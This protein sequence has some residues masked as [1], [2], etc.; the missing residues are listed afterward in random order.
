MLTRHN[1]L[2]SGACNSGKSSLVNAILRRDSALVSDIPGTTADP[3]RFLIEIPGAGACRIID[4]PG[5]DDADAGLGAARS[6]LAFR[7][8]EQADI[9]ILTVG[10][11]PAAEEEFSG[12]A[13]RKNIP[14]ITVAT[15]S[16]L[17]TGAVADIAVSAKTGDGIGE[18]TALLAER[19][20]EIAPAPDLLGGLVAAD[21]I[22]VL[23][24]PQDAEA[25]KD[26]IILPQQMAVRAIL[27]R[28]A[29]P[30]CAT[31]GTYPAAL[32]AMNRK[33]ALVITDSQAFSA[34][35]GLTPADVPLTSFSI[36]MAHHKGDLDLFRRGAEALLAMKGEPA[37]ILIAQACS[38]VPAGED[39]GTVKLPRL[40]RK[41]LGENINITWAYGRNFTDNLAG[42]DLVIHCGACMFTR[43]HLINRLGAITA[44]SVPVTNYGLAIA[45]CLGILD[46]VALPR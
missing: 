20:S 35:R 3:N 11:N 22:V 40:L 37:N 10:F 24:M 18:L 7:E 6:A 45:A 23:V 25:P 29:L 27:D 5:F 17:V 19:L 2:V 39:I 16:D 31:V 43:S 13:R 26:R 46:K 30:L 41:T 34:V 36:L 21:D 33:P 38:H 44:A 15:K 4:S 28:G 9:V 42:F 32:A 12:I 8:I 14:L 1:I